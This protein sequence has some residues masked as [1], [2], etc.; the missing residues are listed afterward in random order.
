M[1]ITELKKELDNLN[2]RPSLYA[3]NGELLPDRIILYRNHN[4]WEVFYFSERGTRHDQKQFDTE[5]EACNYIYELF[6]K[7]Y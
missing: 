2:V 4:R 1:T 7:A 5:T 6:R 3:L